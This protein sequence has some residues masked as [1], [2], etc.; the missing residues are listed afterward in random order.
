MDQILNPQQA[1]KFCLDTANQHY[2]NFPVVSLLTPRKL[3]PPIAAIYTFARTADDIADEGDLDA[4]R[5]IDLLQQFSNKLNLTLS[6][7]PPNEPLFIALQNV[8]DRY[9]IP[10][11]LFHNLL[12]AFTQ[13]VTKTRYGDFSEV[14]D[15]CKLSANPIGR[16]LLHLYAQDTEENI[17][18]SDKICS[19]L[20]IINFLQDVHEDLERGRVYL[21]AN[22]INKF[23]VSIED[24]S[25]RKNTL[26]WQQL[27]DYQIDRVR[28]MMREGSVLT[29]ALKGRLRFNLMMTM[30]GGLRVLEKLE[31]DNSRGLK[32][33]ILLTKKDWFKIL[34]KG[35][36]P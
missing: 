12:A 23:A 21:P 10:T 19:A 18:H 7:S 30:A 20:Q 6:G 17:I 28:I 13:D 24:I 31:K 29:R 34:V 14:L 9:E 25:A 22:D 11:M 26:R 5:R 36:H 32:Q 33:R 4:D 16:I 15:Y 3:R 27:M 8:I 2:E 1:E 35:L